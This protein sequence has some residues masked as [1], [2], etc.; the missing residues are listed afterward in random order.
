M[1]THKTYLMS[2][3]NMKKDQR[4]VVILFLSIYTLKIKDSLLKIK[5]VIYRL[6]IVLKK[7]ARERH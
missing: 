6:L 4:T 7:D 5:G 1:S 2:T 3:G